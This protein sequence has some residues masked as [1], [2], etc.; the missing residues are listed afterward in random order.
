MPTEDSTEQEGISYK[1]AGVDITA[2]SQLVDLIGPAVKATQ[3]SDLQLS[4]IGGFAALTQLPA[5]YKNPVL[6]SG[7]DG[8]GT[9]LELA[10]KYGRHETVG[11]DLVAMC[12]NDV[13]VCGGEPLI[14]L[15]Y[16]ATGKLD[17]DLA[18]K[19]IKGIAKGCQTAGCS[20][21]G[22]E[23][24]EMPGFYQGAQYDLAGFCV[25]IV[26]K[27][28][29][30]DGAEIEKGD[31]IIGLPSSGPHSN[32][33]SLIRKILELKEIENHDLINEMMNPTRIYV[34]SV[35]SLLRKIR[36]K[37]MV[38]ITGGGFYENI[39]RIIPNQQLSANIDL[40]AWERPHIFNWLQDAGRV[41]D[42]EMLTTFNCGIGYLIIVSS[43]DIE[44]T[45]KILTLEQEEPL[46]IGEIVS[47][48]SSTN[49]DQILI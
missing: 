28:K 21:V 29:I 45:T 9:K 10:D 31:K 44:E 20:L 33:F 37:G 14:F 43:E 12:V 48:D 22:G 40:S 38:H 35:L 25:G 4:S 36:V 3:N 1:G 26:E 39:R 47:S 27:D 15:D 7:T 8:V 11:Q 46:L 23:T 19:V 13:L 5:H 41:N 24:A 2:G 18:S 42:R 49:S 16:F 32:G 17:V 34:S 6:V 30:I